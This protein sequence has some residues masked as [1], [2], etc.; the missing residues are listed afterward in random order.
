MP[1]ALIQSIDGWAAKHS[2]GSRSEAIRR[3]VE[4]GLEAPTKK[5]KEEPPGTALIPLGRRRS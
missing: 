4:L 2:D 5:S 1:R 3:L